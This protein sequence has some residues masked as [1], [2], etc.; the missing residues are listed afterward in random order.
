MK[1]DEENIMQEK[2][3]ENADTKSSAPEERNPSEDLQPADCGEKPAPRPDIEY[4]EAVRSGNMD[5]DHE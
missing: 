1:N 4:A 3:E 5:K 2:H